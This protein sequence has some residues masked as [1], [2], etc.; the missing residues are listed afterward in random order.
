MSYYSAPEEAIDDSEELKY[1]AQK[2]CDAAV[3]AKKKRT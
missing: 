3:R 2:G 1:R